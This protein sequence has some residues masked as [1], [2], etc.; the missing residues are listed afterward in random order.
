MATDRNAAAAITE[1]VD[2]RTREVPFGAPHAF[3][4]V[5]VDGDDATAVY[6]IT[7][8]ESVLGRGEEAD[9]AIE[10]EQISKQH[11]RIRVEGSVMTIADLGSRNGTSVNDRRL[12]ANVAQR[13]KNLDEIE[14][15]SHRLL[16]MTGRFRGAVKNAKR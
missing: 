10:D 12:P 14:V 9:I 3:V 4:L 11:C 13:L 1:T 7:R 15:G 16:L 5:V 6:R 2:E 8:T